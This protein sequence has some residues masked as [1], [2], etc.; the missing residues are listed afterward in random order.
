MPETDDPVFHA[1]WEGRVF[2][3]TLAMLK[4]GKWNIDMSRFARESLSR[5]DYLSRAYFQ[6]WLFGLE[7]LLGGS[8]SGCADEIDTCQIRLPQKSVAVLRAS[9]GR[10]RSAAGRVRPSVNQRSRHASR[11]AIAFG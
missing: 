6:I 7:R 2:A 4:P 5:E 11:Q 10:R 8:R 9:E 3:M 1:E